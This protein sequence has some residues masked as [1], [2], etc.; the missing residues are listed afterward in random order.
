ML[1]N[2]P[3]KIKNKEHVTEAIRLL[4]LNAIHIIRCNIL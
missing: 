2:H 4:L 3:D 1:R